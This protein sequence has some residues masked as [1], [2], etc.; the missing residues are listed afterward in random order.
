[1]AIFWPKQQA[2]FTN[3]GH[4]PAV[5]L[6]NTVPCCRDGSPRP[7]V[8]VLHGL[9]TSCAPGFMAPTLQSGFRSEN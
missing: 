9:R 2:L 8:P 7:C 3:L 4:A 6:Q 5:R 1:M